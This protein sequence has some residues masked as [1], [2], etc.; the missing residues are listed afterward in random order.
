MT[1]TLNGVPVTLGA[2]GSTT[3][4]FTP[5][6][7]LVVDIHETDSQSGPSTVTIDVLTGAFSVVPEPATLA[8]LGV[9]I[10]RLAAARRRKLG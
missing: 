6:T 1:E 2:P 5:V 3:T 8:L 7:D 10:A 4:F 9:G